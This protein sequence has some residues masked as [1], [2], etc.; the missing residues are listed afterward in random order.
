MFGGLLVGQNSLTTSGVIY[1]LENLIY[2]IKNH[3]NNH[4]KS[5]YFISF[6]NVSEKYLLMIVNF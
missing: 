3:F 2:I 5:S 1:L 6:L 4:I